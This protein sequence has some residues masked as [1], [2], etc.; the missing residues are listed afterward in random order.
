M[1]AIPWVLAWTQTRLVLLAWL[2]VSLEGCSAS[3]CVSRSAYGVDLG[4]PRGRGCSPH[5]RLS[6]VRDRGAS[7]QDRGAQG[8]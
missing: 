8:C 4:R 6:G 7:V 5:Y 1:R 2:G 3:C